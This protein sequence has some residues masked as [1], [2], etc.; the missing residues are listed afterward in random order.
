M[1]YAVWAGLYAC[2][3][4]KV[5][6]TVVLFSVLGHAWVGIWTVFTDYIKNAPLRAV[7]E[8]LLI[9]F[10]LVLAIAGSWIFWS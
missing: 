4:F 9:L 5:F 3:W 10:L 2:L 7:L 1:T 8:V 6:S